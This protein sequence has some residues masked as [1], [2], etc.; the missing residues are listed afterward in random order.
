MLDFIGIGIG[1]FNLSLAALLQGKES[2]DYLFFEQKKTFSWHEGMLL[3]NTTLQVPFMADLVTMVEPTSSLSFLNYLKAQDRLF[4]FYFLEKLHIPRLEYNHY[5][6]WASQQIKQL[7]FGAEVIRVEAQNHGFRVMVQHQGEHKTYTC[8]HLVFG[9]GTVPTL[10]KCLQTLAKDFPKRCFHSADFAKRM[11]QHRHGDT[12]VLGS[13]QSA[14]EVFDVLLEQQQID[15]ELNRSFQLSWLTRTAGFFPMEYSALGLE[16]FT[17]DYT[18]YFYQLTQETKDL[19][20]PN[21]GL[22]YKGISFSTIGS[23]YEK[24]YHRTIGR[25]ALNVVLSGL[26]ELVDARMEQGRIRLRF[27]H[28]QQQRHFEVSTDYV[29]AATGYRHGLPACMQ[30]LEPILD[31]DDQNRLKIDGA[32]QVKH[33]GSG[34]IFVQNAE[35]HTHGI[36]T[37]DLGLGAYRAAQIANQLLGYEAFYLGQVNTFQRFGAPDDI[38]C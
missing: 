36:G 20:V 8:K 2:L 17:P 4:K 12:V 32:Y 18:R 38:A 29:V 37:P 21:Q 28:L 24:L 1:P 26:S 11:A 27:R 6:Q 34:K 14:A 15:H 31:Y 16:H 22:F 30:G 23:I 13:G 7:R 10:P 9:T 33:H 25:Q 19:L 5:C 35:L 3:P